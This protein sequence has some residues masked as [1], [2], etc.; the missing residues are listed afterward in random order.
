[1]VYA[2]E[3]FLI[4]TRISGLGQMFLLIFKI[5]S[6]AIHMQNKFIIFL[7]IFRVLIC[8]ANGQSDEDVMSKEE[9]I[10]CACNIVKWPRQTEPESY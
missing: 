5:K 3:A 10:N 8:A 1:M 9:I 2:K 4:V 7:I 6:E